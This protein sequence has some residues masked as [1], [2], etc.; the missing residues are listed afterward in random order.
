MK[1]MAEIQAVPIP[2]AY[3][4]SYKSGLTS[5][6]SNAAG[7]QVT[8]WMTGCRLSVRSNVTWE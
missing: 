4:N 6:L 1:S 8:I 2:A 3:P 5:Y 7:F